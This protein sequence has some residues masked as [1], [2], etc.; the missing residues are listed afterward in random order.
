VSGVETFGPYADVLVINVSSPNTPGLRGLQTRT[1]LTDL[2]NGVNAARKKVASTS[3]VARAPKLVVKIAPDLSE[4]ELLD[5]ASV[6]KECEVDGVIVSNTT[7]SRPSSLVN[8]N[9]AEQGGLSGKPLKPYT[10]AALRILRPQ[11]PASVPLIG[12][13]GIS[14]GADAF[15][16]A[17]A[18]ASL[19]QVYTSFGYDGAGACRRIKD[20]LN[21]LLAKEGTTWQ[22]V[23]DDAVNGLS[24]KPVPHPVPVKAEEL[25][26]VG[27]L[28]DEAKELGKL[29]DQPSEEIGNGDTV[30]V[31]TSPL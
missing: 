28:I 27:V 3:R 8:S 21:E 4:P 12:C 7:V 5:I 17:K 15:E 18:G 13:G 22:E 16:Y 25:S 24:W 29:L 14:T 11:V 2:L 31:P 30:S 19:V 10:L 1:A 6:I 9:K 26:N 23:V 20:E